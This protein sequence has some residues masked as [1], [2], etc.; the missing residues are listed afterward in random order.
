[1]EL[2]RTRFERAVN[3]IKEKESPSL[4]ERFDRVIKNIDTTLEE[5]SES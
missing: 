1:M 4:R 2:H 3:A 5:K